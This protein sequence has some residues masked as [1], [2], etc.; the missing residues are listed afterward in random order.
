MF[1]YLKRLDPRWPVSVAVADVEPGVIFTATL[2]NAAP[3]SSELHRGDQVT[4]SWA[5]SAVRQIGG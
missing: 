1:K 4:L 2:L 3:G 5:P